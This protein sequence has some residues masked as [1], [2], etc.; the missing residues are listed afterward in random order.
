MNKWSIFFLLVGFWFGSV[1][2]FDMF[3]G[4]WDLVLW[5]IL[6][7]LVVFPSVYTFDKYNLEDVP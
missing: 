1:L 4:F 3:C 6:S 5:N 2:L 7:M